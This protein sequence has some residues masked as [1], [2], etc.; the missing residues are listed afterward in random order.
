[1]AAGD[2][3]ARHADTKTALSFLIEQVE[4]QLY[5]SQRQRN[6]CHQSNTSRGRG[7]K[8]Y[9]IA[10]GPLSMPEVATV[11]RGSPRVCAALGFGVAGTALS[12][13]WWTPIIFHARNVTPFV[14]FIVSPGISA[15]ICGWALGK[16][17]L[18]P[19]RVCA[20]RSAAVWAGIGTLALL[21]FAPLFSTLYVLTQP[22][23]EHWSIL[24]LAFLVLVGGFLAVWWLVALTGAVVGWGLNRLASSDVG[25]AG[26]W[27]LSP[28]R[29][30]R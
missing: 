10:L 8:C 2:G 18:D 11:L 28:R 20:A 12:I 3:D 24:G 1:M 15:A 29:R 21:L 19:V 4:A 26:T 30:R 13:V 23:T 27:W 22:A 7:S 14:L 25:S 9:K 6:R 16:P 5:S 17:L